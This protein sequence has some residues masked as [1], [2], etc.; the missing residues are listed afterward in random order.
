MDEM[1]HEL[2]EHWERTANNAMGSDYP[3]EEYFL[4]LTRET[5]NLLSH[6]DSSHTITNPV[7]RILVLMQEYAV[8]CFISGKTHSIEMWTIVSGILYDFLNGFE[9]CGSVY[10]KLKLDDV[11]TMDVFD[12]DTDKLSDMKINDERP[13]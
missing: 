13:F 12:F 9:Q 3:K 6:F 11:H 1:M 5:F 10:P 2:L 7:A 8:Y 4:K